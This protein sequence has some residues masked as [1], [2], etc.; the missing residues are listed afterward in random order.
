MTLPRSFA[1]FWGAQLT[2]TSLVEWHR[3]QQGRHVS[4]AQPKEP[5]RAET[6]NHKE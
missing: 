4:Q 3:T 1:L 2:A 5:S 6:E